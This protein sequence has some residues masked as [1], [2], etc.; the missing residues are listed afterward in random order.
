MEQTSHASSSLSTQWLKSKYHMGAV[1][2][3]SALYVIALIDNS[4][5]NTTPSYT[6]Q[7]EIPGTDKDHPE[8][9]G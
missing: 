1:F 5:C 3:S 2:L 4:H 9:A 7:I 6:R 8:D